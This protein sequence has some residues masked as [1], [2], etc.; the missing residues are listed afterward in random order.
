M[1]MLSSKA[2]CNS[3]NVVVPHRQTNSVSQRQ[4]ITF[5]SELIKDTF[6]KSDSF[7]R[8]RKRTSNL[9]R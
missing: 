3:N 2:I 4:K 9:L 7:F 8:F 5:K 1:K 6:S